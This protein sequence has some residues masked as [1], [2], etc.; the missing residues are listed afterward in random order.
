MTSVSLPF[1][2]RSTPATGSDFS[3]IARLGFAGP[4]NTVPTSHLLLTTAHHAMSA[5]TP[6][7][8]PLARHPNSLPSCCDDLISKIEY[9]TV[10]PRWVFVRVESTNGWV[11]WGEATLEG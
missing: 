9:F 2:S 1:A 5:V 11:G 10:M 8:N 6:I 3:Y 4:Q 7:P